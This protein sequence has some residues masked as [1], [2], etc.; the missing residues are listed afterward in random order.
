[1]KTHARFVRQGLE[2]SEISDH[3]WR[4]SDTRVAAIGAPPVV[5]FILQLD[6]MYEVTQIG[7]PGRR[8]YFR[9]FDAAL[10][11]LHG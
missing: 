4:V 10:A 6:A 9:S 8:T 2:V 3:E 5:G 7:R 11:E 1:M